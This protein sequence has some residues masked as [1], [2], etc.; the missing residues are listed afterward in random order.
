M[1]QVSSS[2]GSAVIDKLSR[3]QCTFI[4]ENKL[5][6]FFPVNLYCSVLYQ[7]MLLL[8]PSVPSTVPSTFSWGIALAPLSLIILVVGAIWMR[9]RCKRKAGKT[10]GLTKLRTDNQDFPSSPNQIKEMK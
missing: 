4:K 8:M 1:S 9:R 6:F 2:N 3:N 5:M 10:Y 7:E